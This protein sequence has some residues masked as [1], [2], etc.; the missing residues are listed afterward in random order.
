ME[1]CF[2]LMIE[3]AD[4][5]RIPLVGYRT[6]DAAA[7]EHARRLQ[8]PEVCEALSLLGATYV[9]QPVRVIGHAES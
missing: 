7:N 8:L 2:L 4:G 6:A 1:T 9:V 5:H 3:D